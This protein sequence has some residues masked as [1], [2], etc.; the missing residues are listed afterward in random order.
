MKARL[1]AIGLDP[2][3]YSGHSLRSGLITSA[4]ARRA[5]VFK[6]QEASQHRRAVR[7]RAQRQLVRGPL[8]GGCAVSGT[9]PIP[10]TVPNERIKL[11]A[12]WVSNIGVGLVVV[13]AVTPLVHG[14]LSLRAAVWA[15]IYTGMGWAVHRHAR[16]RLGE[17]QQ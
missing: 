12:T 10:S 16:D 8:R 6:I 2:A 13:G 3:L 1:A 9:A 4:A 17:L 5:L 7:L 11:T 15:L 14:E